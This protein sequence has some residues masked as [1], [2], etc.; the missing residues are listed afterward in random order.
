MQLGQAQEHL[1]RLLQAPRVCL[2]VV[3]LLGCRCLHQR[4]RLRRLPRD[5]LRELR[6]GRQGVHRRR[7]RHAR[8]NDDALSFSGLKKKKNEL[9][10]FWFEFFFFF[11]KK[12]LRE[13]KKKKKKKKKKS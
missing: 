11:K 4:V 10:F 7:R 3:P 12:I 2:R 1:P 5:R 13:K 9:V 6:L 8:L